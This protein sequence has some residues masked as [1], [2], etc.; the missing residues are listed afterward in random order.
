MCVFLKNWWWFEWFIKKQ[1]DAQAT[2]LEYSDNNTDNTTTI[3]SKTSKI[4]RTKKID[5][6]PIKSRKT[7]K[8]EKK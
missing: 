3:D 5:K 1:G 6:P 4:K 8:K 2:K 7:V